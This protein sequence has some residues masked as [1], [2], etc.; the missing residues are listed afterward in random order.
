M[1]T[2]PARPAR[3]PPEGDSPEHSPG[4]LANPSPGPL[5]RDRG[6]GVTGRYGRHLVLS[7]I[8]RG[9]TAN[10]CGRKDRPRRLTHLKLAE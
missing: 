4:V 9:S 8:R 1:N 2:T 7:L 10:L 3:I 6:L 5:V